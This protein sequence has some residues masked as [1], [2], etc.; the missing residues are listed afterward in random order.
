[1]YVLVCRSLFRFAKEV[2]SF[3]IGDRV[4]SEFVGDC[5]AKC[6]LNDHCEAWT[7]YITD[8]IKQKLLVAQ[9]TFTYLSYL[10]IEQMPAG[11]AILGIEADISDGGHGAAILQHDYFG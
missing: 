3:K 10:S 6:R 4:S 7:F 2:H 11:L 1:M 5:I 9:C 8:V